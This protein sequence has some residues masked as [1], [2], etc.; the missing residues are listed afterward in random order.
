M[1]TLVGSEAHA[2]GDLIQLQ[3]LQAEAQPPQAGAAAEPQ[4]PQAGL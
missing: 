1:S 2:S 4:P 3:E